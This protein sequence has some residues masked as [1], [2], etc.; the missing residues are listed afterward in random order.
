MALQPLVLMGLIR[1][2]LSLVSQCTASMGAM[3]VA[4]GA[5]VSLGREGWIGDELARQEALWGGEW[6]RGLG[7]RVPLTGGFSDPVF[8]VHRA[9]LLNPPRYSC[10]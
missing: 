9:E 8:Q 4:W 1:A 5:E 6:S 3:V 10:C 7:P 2:L